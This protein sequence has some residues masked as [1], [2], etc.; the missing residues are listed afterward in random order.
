MGDALSDRRPSR[1]ER[2][3]YGPAPFWIFACALASVALL[4]AWK[5]HER[6]AMRRPDLLLATFAPQHA[7]M[8]RR[9]LPEFER[10]HGVRVEVQ[11]LN[12]E[13]LKG[14]LRNALLSGTD[15]PDLVELSDDAMGFF[16]SGP[17]E[18]VGFV[19]L[20]DRLRAEGLDRA[21]VPSRFGLWSSRGRVFA[22]PH[23][24]HPV[25]LAYRRDLT[26]ALG[27]DV[28]QLATWD[29]FAAVGRK[30]TRDLDGDGVVDR[31]A[32]D[33]PI[34]AHGLRLLVAQRGG[35]LFDAAGRAAFDSAETAE[36]IDWYVRALEGPARFATS[37]G[38]GQPMVQ[39]LRDGLVLFTL[40][41]DW[42]TRLLEQD[43]PMLTGKMAL[44]PLPAFAPGARRTTTWG[45]TGLAITRRTRDVGLAWT[46]AKWLYLAKQELGRRFAE[47]NIIAPWR[48][49]WDAPELARPNPYWSGQPLGRLFAA[50]APDVPAVYASGAQALGAA[51]L[52]DVFLDALAR[53][54]TRG[55]DDLRPYVLQ[56][57]HD[58]AD[59]V[60]AVQARNVFLAREA[61]P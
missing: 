44:M 50:L 25:M 5:A 51:K 31:Y 54:R 57:L 58:A 53:F 20:T 48:Q 10:T 41:S 32:L 46:L 61:A 33:L 37:A 34:G 55:A 27:V 3:P 22:L 19:D 39:A 60:R 23:D 35:E 6:R 49:A 11:V 17:L 16:T 21:I 56:R 30:L 29:D 24:V 52:D 38:W 2:F 15:V 45:G 8:Y 28:S 13:A 26:D 42:R 43:A 59:R 7:E 1:A 4:V 47:T 36:V 14:R 18:D 9:L 40:A 12:W